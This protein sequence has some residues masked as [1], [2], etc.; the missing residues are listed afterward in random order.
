MNTKDYGSEVCDLLDPLL[1]G[2]AKGKASAGARLR[3]E[4][5]S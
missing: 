4:Y 1:A 5:V 2:G 3:S